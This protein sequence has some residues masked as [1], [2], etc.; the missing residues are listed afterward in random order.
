MN[1]NFAA[2]WELVCGADGQEKSFVDFCVLQCI[3]QRSDIIEFMLR[4]ARVYNIA[5]GHLSWPE[6]RKV[7][8]DSS[9][10]SKLESMDLNTASLIF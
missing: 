2:G 4:M 9:S 1:K 10:P 5:R 8:A 6:R 7:F 3:L